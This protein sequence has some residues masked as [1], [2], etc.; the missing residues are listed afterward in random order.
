[1]RLLTHNFLHSSHKAGVKCGY[2]LGLEVSKHEVVSQE[3]DSKFVIS[4][5]NRIDWSCFVLG[6]RALGID[7]SIIPHSIDKE[8]VEDDDELLNAIHSALLEIHVLEGELI[9]PQT[10]IFYFQPIEI[11]RGLLWFECQHPHLS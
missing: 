5:L 8:H 7:D 1:M 2:P 10:G 4:M 6:A 9:C 11:K 3:F